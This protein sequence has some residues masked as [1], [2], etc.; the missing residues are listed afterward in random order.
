[1]SIEG[2]NGEESY[3]PE[4]EHRNFTEQLVRD[5]AF[6]LAEQG[7]VMERREKWECYYIRGRGYLV[8]DERGCLAE[9]RDEATAKIITDDHNEYAAL[10]EQRDSLAQALRDVRAKFFEHAQAG[11]YVEKGELIPLDNEQHPWIPGAEAPRAIEIID[12]A[13]ATVE[14]GGESQ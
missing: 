1:M 4:R 9:V 8:R 6:E 2:F 3:Y 10:V 13:L 12:N 5:G 11:A 14:Q 7:D